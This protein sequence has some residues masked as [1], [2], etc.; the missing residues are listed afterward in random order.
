MSD[1][2]AMMPVRVLCSARA[3]VA[4]QRDAQCG[5]L[6]PIEDV[7]GVDR[8]AMG[9]L[10]FRMLRCGIARHY[11]TVWIKD[12]DDLS[13]LC[14]VAFRPFEVSIVDLL[15]Y[16]SP[17]FLVASELDGAKMDASTTLSLNDALMPALSTILVAV[18][19][20]LGATYLTA[21]LPPVYKRFSTACSALSTRRSSTSKTPSPPAAEVSQTSDLPSDW[22]TSPTQHALETRAILSKT[23]LHLAHTSTLPKPGSY[24]TF[25]IAN[26]SILLIRGKDGILRAFHNICR[27]RAYTVATKAEGC[28][29][30]LMC[31][32][33]GWTYDSKGKL[34][35]AP[36]FE[37]VAG[38]DRGANGLFEVRTFVD[39]SGFVYVNLDVYGSDGLTIRVGVPIRAKLQHLESWSV[40]AP[41]NWKMAVPQGSFRIA[42]M[43][44]RSR[45]P[46]LKRLLK[47]SLESWR[48][49]AEFELSPL[50]HLIRSAKGDL[51]LTISIVPKTHTA[52]TLACA[53]YTSDQEVE[54][55][56]LAIAAIKAEVKSSV[57]DLAET[58]EKVK[59]DGDTATDYAQEPLLAECKAHLRLERFM[60]K[61][62]HPASRLRESSRECKVADDLCQELE[63]EAAGEAA[64]AVS[65]GVDDKLAW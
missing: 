28:S 29:Q 50:T 36:K 17:N 40:D 54:T 39:S 4:S 45:L 57:T 62:I 1:G 3:G 55:F 63:T 7:L 33:H 59:D 25:T 56:Q 53:L 47:G 16:S 64:S 5:E 22:W 8:L 48:W 24:K 13:W 61:E 12:I 6:T 19:V 38:F 51:W 10:G 34:I 49:A 23:W 27:H 37:D 43:A 18:A 44:M 42:S 15:S 21:W 2:F 65:G 14:C 35:R 31:K 30:V 20:Y 58:F 46:D 32:Y 52:S 11:V 9:W 60:G 41:F 26:H